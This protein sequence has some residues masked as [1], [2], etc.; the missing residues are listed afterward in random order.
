[1]SQLWNDVLSVAF[2]MKSFLV[3]LHVYSPFP[4]PDGKIGFWFWW[5]IHERKLGAN[6]WV[7]SDSSKRQAQPRPP[8]VTNSCVYITEVTDEPTTQSDGSL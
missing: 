3:K 7:L 6:I 2:K 8:T 5:E 1:M 4:D